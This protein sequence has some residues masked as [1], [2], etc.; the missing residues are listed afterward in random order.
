MESLEFIDAAGKRPLRFAMRAD[1]VVRPVQYESRRHW[2]L[3]DPVT[4]RFWQLAE[5]EYF[6]LA[7]LDGCASADEILSRFQVRFA[8]RR[9]TGGALLAFVA[10]LHQDRLITAEVSGQ[11]RVNFERERELQRRAWLERA[12]NVLAIRFRGVDPDRWLDRIAPKLAW[13]FSPLVAA[14]Y[15][16]MLLS[17]A[18]LVGLQWRLVTSEIQAIASQ[19]TVS[20]MLWLLLIVAGVKVLHEL[21]HAIACKHFGGECHE[22]GLM[23]LVGI[24]TLYCNVSSAWLIE[25]KWRRMMVSAAGMV[26]ELG[27]A[28]LGTWLWWSSAPGTFHSLCLYV[29][30]LCSLNTLV[31]NG[32]PFLQYDGY[33]LLSDAMEVPNLR[34]QAAHVVH[35]AIGRVVLGVREP[36]EQVAPLRGRRWLATYG[37]LSPIYGICLAIA[38]V[39]AAHL[40][41]RPYDLQILAWLV[42]LPLAVSMLAAPAVQLVGFL[43]RANRNDQVAWRFVVARTVLVAAVAFGALAVPFPCNISA[44]VVF[45]P[46]GEQTVYVTVPGWLADGVEY[47]ARLQQGDIIARLENA[48]LQ[49][50]VER[51]AGEAQVRRRRLVHLRTR[52]GDPEA[53]AQIPTA[54]KALADSEE[55]L[56]RRKA[57]LERLVL[58]APRDGIVLP[59][60]AVRPASDGRPERWSGAPLDP[61]NRGATLDVGTAVCM[62]GDPCDMDAVLLV[63]QADAPAVRTGQQVELLVDQFPA[64][65]LGGR[66]HS[67][68]ESGSHA[69]PS[70][71]VWRRELPLEFRSHVDEASRLREPR[72]PARVVLDDEHRPLVM[73]A[74]G[75]AKVQVAPRSLAERLGRVL[76]RTF[77]AD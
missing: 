1:L 30:V 22:I 24:P 25:S 12:M 51:L 4:G 32:N 10:Q 37:L 3:K 62:V 6:V 38:V 17:A 55:Q 61:A 15:V 71:L 59:P 26:I 76:R 44:P 53:A 41:L 29:M 49:R 34:Q 74:T 73:G 64:I 18:L 63:E 2:N 5:E 11:G 57:E 8:P 75:W 72:F 9:L 14:G 67:A 28:S 20:M 70:E 7:A 48:E 42:A 77:N 21:G 52:Q 69:A 19:L 13:L 50:E 36:E 40:A 46:H 16:A 66:I 58:R 65:A 27:L 23:L 68:S 39:A 54:V 33:F 56:Q 47:G 45:E 43:R 35:G 60:R 31:V